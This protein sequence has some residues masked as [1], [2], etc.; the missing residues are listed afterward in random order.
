MSLPTK[1]FVVM[2]V[3]G[4]GKSSVARLLAERSGGTFLDA[5]DFHPAANKAKMTAGVPLTDE[6][7]WP[8]LDN[9]NARLKSLAQTEPPVFLACSALRQ[10]Y[11]DRLIADLSAL[12]FIYLQGSEELIR[13]RMEARQDHFMPSALLSSQF[14][15]LEEPH[16]AITLWIDRPVSEI[17]ERILRAIQILQA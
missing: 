17:V 11:R 3:S 8:W 12:R 16:D 10:A 15:A 7:R 9:L 2:G 6:D 14:A 4:C 5:D 13:S 1:H